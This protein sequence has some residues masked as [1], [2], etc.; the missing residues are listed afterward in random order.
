MDVLDLITRAHRAER[1]YLVVQVGRDHKFLAVNRNVNPDFAQ[2]RLQVERKARSPIG[3]TD[4]VVGRCH[5]NR[6]RRRRRRN[7]IILQRCVEALLR[8]DVFFVVVDERRIVDSGIRP[9]VIEAGRS[10]LLRRGCYISGPEFPFVAQPGMIFLLRFY[11]RKRSKL[12]LGSNEGL[13]YC[14]AA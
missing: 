13:T 8:R 12:S 5:Q 11:F 3:L 9:V 4:R 14:I 10:K 6:R 7:A 1:S 2:T